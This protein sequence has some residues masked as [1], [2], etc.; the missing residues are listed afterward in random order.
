MCWYV[1]REP[2]VPHE[3]MVERMVRSTSIAS[4]VHGVE[5]DNN[6]LY[7]TMVIDVMRMN[8]SHANQ[9][10]IVDEEPNANTT[11]F[12]FYLL[13]D[14]DKPLWDSCTNHSKLSVIAQ[15]FTIKSNYRLSEVGYDRIVEWA[16]SIL[17]KEN[18][19][20]EN[21]YSANCMITPLGLGYQKI[22]MF[23]N[24]CICT[25]LKMLR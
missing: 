24:F 22:N 8:Q 16:R 15:V 23:P 7:T 6:N 18:M 19:L 17:P 1:H 5:I 11:R 21:F 4:N 14:Y 2:F 10:P 25:T 3:I 12:F 20:K 9:Y 13:K